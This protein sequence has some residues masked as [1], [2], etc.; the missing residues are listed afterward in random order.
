MKEKEKFMR[1]FSL[2]P[3]SEKK[4]PVVKVGNKIYSWEEA[5]KEI[6]KSSAIAKKII[7]NLK[8]NGLL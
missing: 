1:I 7:K 6:K 8:R 3:S 2:L 5:Y 4:L